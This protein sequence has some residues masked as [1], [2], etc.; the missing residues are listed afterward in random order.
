MR[1]RLWFL[2]VLLLLVFA[3]CAGGKGQTLGTTNGTPSVSDGENGKEISG[4][5]DILTVTMSPEQK[6]LIEH[7]RTAHEDEVSAQMVEQGYYHEVNESHTDGIFR[8]DFKAVTGD[9]RDPRLV[10]DVYVND[11]ELAAECE[12]IKLH[13]YVLGEEAYANRLNSYWPGEAL[14]KK[15]AQQDNLYHVTLPG[16]YVWMTMGTPFVV[17]VCQVDFVK[18]NGDTVEYP[19]NV[20]ETRLSVSQYKFYPVLQMGYTDLSF[21]YGGRKY[22]LHAAEYGQYRTEL[23]FYCYVDK[24][25]VYMEPVDF[26]YLN[27]SFRLI[28]QEF[29]SNVTLEAD[30]KMYDINDYGSIVFSEDGSTEEQYR[31]RGFAYT[32]SVNFTKAKEVKI[33]VGTVGYDLKSGSN[34]PFTRELP[35]PTPT[36]V[37]EINEEQI[38]FAEALRNEYKDEISASLVEQGYYYIINET[39]ED[40]I[41]RFDF[42]GLTGDKENRRMAFDVYVEDAVLTEMYPVLRLDVH[43]GYEEDYD[44]EGWWNCTGYGIQDAE[45]KK[46]YHVIMNGKIF[47]YGPAITRICR[48]GFDMDTNDSNG[49]LVYEV[50]PETYRV[51]VSSDVFAPVL[52]GSYYGMKFSCGSK[53]YELVSVTYGEYY[54]DF[55]F[56]TAIDAS[57]VPTDDTELWNYRDEI[58]KDWAEFF[59]TLTLVADGKEYKVVDEEGKRGYLW[60]NV[61]EGADSYRG[62]IHPFFPAIDY[63]EVSELEL[64]AGDTVYRLK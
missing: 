57:E 40:A 12:E 61:E 53:A 50:N 18:K 41:F 7:L 36:P 8:I 38:E 45:N 22:V 9:M 25:A 59:P 51:D 19:V 64:M 43:C 11:A 29:L 31:G 27:D 63:F 20:P 15:D 34:T 24:D 1:K 37:P 30:G 23:S 3:G 39:R 33:W 54:A 26:D 32:P 49:E 55:Y 48:V 17:D 14:G 10:F 46:L 56:R 44:P 13:A 42:K 62:D 58:Q 4:E 21:T 35:M 5:K 47:G 2:A 60:F 16:P 28:W 52:N 6:E